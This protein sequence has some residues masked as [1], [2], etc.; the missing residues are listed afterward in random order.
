MRWPACKG[1]V[2]ADG[3]LHEHLQQPPPQRALGAG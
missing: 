3:P 1:L 2:S